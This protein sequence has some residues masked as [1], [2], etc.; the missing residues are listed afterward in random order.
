MTNYDIHFLLGGESLN[1]LHKVNGGYCYD[2]DTASAMDAK[3]LLKGVLDGISDIVGVYKPDNTVMFYNKAGYEFYGVTPEEVKGKKCFHMLSRSRRCEICTTQMALEQGKLVKFK[4]FIPEMGR[5]IECSAN[6]VFDDNGEIILIIEQLRDITEAMKNELLI[7]QKEEH[8]RNLVEQSRDAIMITHN[9]RVLLANHAASELFGIVYEDML[10][11]NVFDVISPEYHDLMKKRVEMLDNENKLDELAEY[12][13]VTKSGEEKY[14]EVNSNRI[15]FNGMSSV[16][17][18]MRDITERKLEL[19]RAARIQLQ[20]LAAEFPLPDKASL[21]SIYIPAKGIS[22]DFYHV[23]RI[24]SNTVVGL[25]GD[26]CG[27][28]ISAALTISAMKVLFYQALQYHINPAHIL[29]FINERIDQHFPEDYVAACC[30]KL[31]FA[32]GKLSVSCAAINEFSISHEGNIQKIEMPGAFLGMLEDTEFEIR[33]FDIN[34]GDK[35]Y[36]YTDGY[37]LL[38]DRGLLAPNFIYENDYESVNS[39]LVSTLNGMTGI[40]DDCTMMF[41]EII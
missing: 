4:K 7:K 1:S 17:V 15:M 9:Y 6:P 25:I 13:I 8:Y 11:I 12:K 27:K 30:F 18:V 36:F 2:Q 26:A 5:Y 22:G 34:S 16:Q 20:R 10:G 32:V 39:A 28:G 21:K 31:N 14:I 41:I 24:D 29:D 35:L 3:R 19:E 40:K 33:D 23:H 38:I 37:Q